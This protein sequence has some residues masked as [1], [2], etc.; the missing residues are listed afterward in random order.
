MI[1][2]ILIIMI[3]LLAILYVKI[4]KD[5][6]DI[7]NDTIKLFIELEGRCAFEKLK[8]EARES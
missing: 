8:R 3:V 6:N 2:I 4:L 5:F 7:T 1:E